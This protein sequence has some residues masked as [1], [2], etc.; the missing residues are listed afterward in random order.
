MNVLDLLAWATAGLVLLASGTV[1]AHTPAPS[2]QPDKPGPIQKIVITKHDAQSAYGSDA[3]CSDMLIDAA[4]VRYFWDN[5]IEGTAQEYRRG[6]DLADCEG[7]AEVH[8][9]SR[10]KGQLSLDGATGWGSLD[11][12]GRT[13]Y[14]YCPSCEGILGQNFK[15]QPNTEQ[16][17]K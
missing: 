6:L 1:Q 5:A 15:P 11:Y 7:T 12:R 3:N 14:F 16:Q 8:F 10:G 9:K 13:R 4:R 17:R 2:R